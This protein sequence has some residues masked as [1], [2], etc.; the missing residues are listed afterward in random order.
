MRVGECVVCIKDIGDGTYIPELLFYKKGDIYRITG[1]YPHGVYTIKA[2][3]F[4]FYFTIL[5]SEQYYYFDDY[6]I[7]LKECRKNKL[8]KINELY[9]NI[10]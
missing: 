3:T 7:T 10:H 9:E 5:H 4:S 6:F 8:K 1:V 2:R